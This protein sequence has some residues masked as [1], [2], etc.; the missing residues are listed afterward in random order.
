[1]ERR[2][3]MGNKVR[4]WRPIWILL[5][6]AVGLFFLYEGLVSWR[7]SRVV[8]QTGQSIQSGEAN[9]AARSL[10]I[11]SQLRPDHPDLLPMKAYFASRFSPA[12][13]PFFWARVLEEYPEESRYRVPAVLAAI[14]GRQ[15]EKARGWVDSFVG[16]APDDPETWRAGLALA[17]ARGDMERSRMFA[18]RLVKQADASVLDQ[19]NFLKLDLLGD[20]PAASA[21]AGKA[22]RGYLQDLQ[23]RQDV[24]NALLQEAIQNDDIRL[25]AEIEEDLPASAL[26]DFDV[27]FVMTEA[28]ARLGQLPDT[29]WI[30][31]LWRMTDGAPFLQSRLAGWLVGIGKADSL[32]KLVGPL[33]AIR[34]WEFPLG[35]PVAEACLNEGRHEEAL[36]GLAQVQWRGVEYLK[37]FMEARLAARG[38]GNA[39]ETMIQNALFQASE[40][41]GGMEHLQ[42]AAKTWNWQRGYE[43]VIRWQINNTPVDTPRFQNLMESAF[44]QRDLKALRMGSLRY[45]ETFPDHPASINNLAYFSFLLDRLDAETVA[46]L[47]KVHRAY[48]QAVELTRT[49]ILLFLAQSRLEDAMSLMPRLEELNTP[50]DAWIRFWIQRLQGQPPSVEDV[51]LLKTHKFDFPE[52]RQKVDALLGL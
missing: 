48:P 8:T 30:E 39:P 5:L 31:E 42:N 11:L 45:L 41:P 36:R 3:W 1:M 46:K 51:A 24:L 17:F 10:A 20:D 47:E 13:A 18:G 14:K 50:T 52:E 4:W 29:D 44:Q 23:V 35:L 43:A 40:R 26:V 33:D 2:S 6:V 7:T 12:Q 19:V 38:M 49:L 28:R 9:E 34:C 25:I 37:I 27:A 22:L 21:E 16:S 15:F 32:L